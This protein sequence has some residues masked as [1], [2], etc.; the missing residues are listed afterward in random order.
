FFTHA[1]VSGLS[2]APHT[3]SLLTSA[4]PYVGQNNTVQYR[5]GSDSRVITLQGGMTVVGSA[6]Q[7]S[8]PHNEANYLCIASNINWSGCPAMGTN[9][10]LA[11]ADIVIP[12]GHNGVVLITGKT[13]IQGDPADQGGQSSLFLSIDGVTHGAVGV[14]DLAYPDAVSTRTLGASYLATGANALSP[15]THHVVLYGRATGS[16]MHLA[17]TKDLPLIWFD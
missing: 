8:D 2:N 14:Q 17:T 16:F 4:I 11:E 6:P 13:R 1:L 7:A 12:Q 10:V 9:T 3:I 15:G 5:M